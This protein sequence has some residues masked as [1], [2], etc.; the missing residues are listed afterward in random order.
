MIEF[1]HNYEFDKSAREM[2]IVVWAAL[3]MVN[4]LNISY[5]IQE[6]NM[7]EDQRKVG[8]V[9]GNFTIGALF[10]VRHDAEGSTG[11]TVRC[12]NIRD[13]YGMQRVEAALW[14]INKINRFAAYFDI[15]FYGIK[16]C[17]YTSVMDGA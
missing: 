7:D 4:T 17:T 2:I 15:K 1:L 14:T 11:Q 3:L 10:S 9:P 16:L 6:L 13:Q 8:Y 5:A 12:G